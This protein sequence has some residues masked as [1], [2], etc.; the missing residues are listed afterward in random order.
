MSFPSRLQ[1]SALAGALTLLLALPAASSAR[2]VLVAGGAP[3]LVSVDQSTG[4][5]AAPLGLGGPAVAVATGGDG[6]RAYVGRRPPCRD[7]RDRRPAHRRLHH[8][9]LG[10][11]GARG[12]RQRLAPA[13]RPPRRRR[14]PRHRPA[15]G[16][17]R[18]DRARV[19]DPALDRHLTGRRPR[20]GGPRRAAHR[21]D[22]SDDAARE[23]PRRAGQRERRGVRAR[24]AARSP[25]SARRPAAVWSGSTSPPRAP[26]ASSRSVPGSA[27]AWRSRRTGA[28]RSPAPPAPPR[29]PRS[30]TSR[31]GAW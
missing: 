26:T 25:S 22:R 18:D 7:R 19:G 12:E 1:L 10:R 17:R 31:P 11:H 9:A 23:R 14:R 6:A 30:P 21:R 27:A 15:A 13:R 29:S 3:G 16:R 20:L 8:A 5:V 24:A 28:R 4:R 2:A